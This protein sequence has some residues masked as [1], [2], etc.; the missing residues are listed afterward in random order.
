MHSPGVQNAFKD[1]LLIPELR[2]NEIHEHRILAVIPIKTP[3]NTHDLN[4]LIP[5]GFVHHFLLPSW[6]D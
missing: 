6:I 5:S 1:L 3:S 2:L 4:S